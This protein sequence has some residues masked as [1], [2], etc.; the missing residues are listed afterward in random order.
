MKIPNIATM[1]DR[2]EPLMDL[3]H[4][5]LPY[6]VAETAGCVYT[7]QDKRQERLTVLESASGTPS[8]QDQSL[9]KIMIEATFSQGGET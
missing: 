6:P 5:N 8:T 4:C 7:E 3:E 2:L 9:E 1:E